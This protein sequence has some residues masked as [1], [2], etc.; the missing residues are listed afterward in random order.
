MEDTMKE[1]K[2]KKIGRDE[3]GDVGQRTDISHQS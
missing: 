2:K 3:R 1:E